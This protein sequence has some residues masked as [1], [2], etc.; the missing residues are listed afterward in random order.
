MW[1]WVGV[2][3]GVIGLLRALG[4]TARQ[5]HGIFLA[6]AILLTSLGGLA[7]L[8]FGLA[9][10]FLMQLIL[11][12]IPLVAPVEYVLA[13]LLMSSVA[14]LVSGVSPARRAANLE[15]VEALRAE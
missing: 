6:E 11:P 7:G 5:V 12:G 1:I 4:A 2:G 14:G 8:V 9:I 13:A 10:M 15:P 3:V